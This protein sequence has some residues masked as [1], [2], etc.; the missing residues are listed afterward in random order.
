MRGFRAVTLEGSGFGA[1]LVPC[2][3]LLLFGAVFTAVALARFRFDEP[4]AV[5]G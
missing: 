2:G 1:V 5:R 3:V 4:K